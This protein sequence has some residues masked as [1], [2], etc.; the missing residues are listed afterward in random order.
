MKKIKGVQLILF[1]LDGTLLHEDKNINMSI[2]ELLN[3]KKIPFTFISGRTFQMM[4]DLLKLFDVH[5]PYVTNN[6]ANIFLGNQCIYE[7]C[8]ELKELMSII[9]ILR[10][11]NISFL[12]YSNTKVFCEG[13]QPELLNFKKRIEDKCEIVSE[14]KDEEI[15]KS[16]IFKIV[17]VKSD[18]EFFFDAC[19]EINTLCKKSHCVQSE[20]AV[21][22]I[23]H[24]DISKGE[25]TQW[26]LN[27]LKVNKE[28]VLAFGD[29]YNDVPMFKKVGI[30]VAMNNSVKEVKNQADYVT[31]SND[32]DGVT[33]FIKKY[34]E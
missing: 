19:K 22:T 17:I 8:I 18:S 6:G 25:A 24:C 1:D 29:N 5:L 30:S 31:L 32:E 9:Q 3:D 20:D 7:K 28:K 33:W 15:R 16:N 34:I 27:Y 26:L 13:E 2:V 11:Y 23:N 4:Q 10:T 12:A 21:F 14:F